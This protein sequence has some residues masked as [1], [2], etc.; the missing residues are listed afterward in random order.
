[1][2][3][4]H[5][6]REACNNYEKMKGIVEVD[7]AYFGGK[8]KN[9]HYNKRNH[10]GRG[11][12]NKTAVAG[13]KERNKKFIGRVLKDTSSHTLQNL[14][15]QNVVQNSAVFTDDFLSYVELENKGFKHQSVKHSTNEYVDGK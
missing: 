1:M 9:K 10:K 6:I 14:I 13:L 4:A 5:R 12:A 11:V 2:N 7:E 8:E 3:M 15:K